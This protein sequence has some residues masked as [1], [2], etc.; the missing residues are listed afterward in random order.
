MMCATKYDDM[1][2]TQLVD[3]V[4]A[5]DNATDRELALLD[6]VTRAVEEIELLVANLAQL[7]FEIEGAP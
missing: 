1:T 7:Q 2:L 4:L 5:D 3:E 6:H